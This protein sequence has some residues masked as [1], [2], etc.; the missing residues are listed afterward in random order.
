MF[1][2]S[3]RMTT[4][5]T[6]SAPAS[7]EVFRQTAPAQPVLALYDVTKRFGGAIAL[8][9]VD[10][11]LFPGE[12]HGLVGENG[13]GKSTLVKILSGVQ[14]PDQGEVRM[15][16][17][18]VRF[19]SPADAM[20]HGIGM[21]FQE[22]SM[23]PALTVAENVFLGRQ[24]TNRFGLVDWKTINAEA[25]RQ[26]AE[27]G[28]NIDVTDR[29]G[30]LSLGSQQLVEITRVINSGA[31]I[32]ILDEPTSAISVPE[33]QRLFEL[34]RELQ[35]RGK[36]L[37]FISHFLEDVLEISDRVTVLKNSR[38]VATLP[39]TELSK[40]KLIEL[41]IG[42]DATDLTESYQHAIKLPP[43]SNSPPLLAVDGLTAK[44]EFQDICFTVHQG[45]I[46]G[47]FGYLGAGMTEVAR[48]LFGTVRTQSGTIVLDGEAIRPKSP[49]HAKRLGIAYL[50]ENRRATLFPKQ[51]IYKNVTLAHLDHLVKQFF[52]HPSEVRVT[53]TLIERT[54]VRPRNAVMRAGHLS[55]GNQQKVVLAKWLTKQPKL[56]I[57]NEPT[58]GMDVGAK[59][60]VLDLVKE[61][62]AEGVSILLL[63][64][65]PETILAES[66]RILVMSK[67]KITKEFVNQ[68]VSKE[69]IL[70]Y[71]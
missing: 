25:A 36:T 27:F 62:R 67:G 46:L 10:F 54:G 51:E 28:I 26:M 49:S 5:E 15:Q 69:D 18:V 31:D 57:L 7:G 1:G 17:D 59:R 55:G 40:P 33:A 50:T 53:E 23:M 30:H 44:G 37:I 11:E 65:E 34:M 38:K 29:L 42:K 14:R 43:E 22:L 60:E 21:I 70:L 41:M 56:L 66:D 4:R 24:P 16:G 20:S 3:R 61:L 9:G 35:T 13:A 64:T 68:D 2:G 19:R 48:A 47:L 39:A 52:R 6:E 58:R 45:E 71:A 63:S 32:I 12:I 8:S